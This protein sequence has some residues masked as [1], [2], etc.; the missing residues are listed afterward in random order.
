MDNTGRENVEKRLLPMYT[1][2]CGDAQGGE[3]KVSKRE[4]VA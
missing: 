2:K 3:L 1:E 4:M